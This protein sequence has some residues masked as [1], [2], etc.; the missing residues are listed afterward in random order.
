M[1]KRLSTSSV[2]KKV[3]YDFVKFRGRKLTVVD[4]P[5][6]LDTSCT[7]KEAAELVFSSI[8]QAVF[9][10]TKGYDAIIYVCKLGRFTKE[11]TEVLKELKAAFGPDFVQKH[12]IMVV[13]HAD[14]YDTEEENGVSIM[15]FLN[16]ET[17]EFADT[18]K[19]CCHR[20][21]TF[22]NAT[23]DQSI[24]DEQIEKLLKFVDSIVADIGRYNKGLFEQAREAR[25]KYIEEMKTPILSDELIGDSV[26]ILE[27]IKTI[28]VSDRDTAIKQIKTYKQKVNDL[29]E[30]TDKEDRGTGKLQSMFLQCKTMAE[31][32]ANK[33][34]E[35]DRVAG[36][37]AQIVSLSKRTNQGDDESKKIEELQK[38]NKQMEA[39]IEHLNRQITK[40]NITFFLDCMGQVLGLASQG[41]SVASQWRDFSQSRRVITGRRVYNTTAASDLPAL[42]QE[43]TEDKKREQ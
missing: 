34:E 6:L 19:E 32:L 27:G 18:K 26:L 1:T 15:Q 28:D 37:N 24:K 5:G 29:K 3:D 4:C 14:L 17:G 7:A 36:L 42:T 11:D 13:S 31:L 39:Q 2:T 10:N 40:E 9:I 23:N 16:Q 33:R 41:I 8:H 38:I 22:D 20:V 43:P 35:V 30:R 12:C 25:N 21:V